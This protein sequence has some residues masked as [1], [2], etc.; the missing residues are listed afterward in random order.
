LAGAVV[1]TLPAYPGVAGVVVGCFN[2][3]GK[4]AGGLLLLRSDVNWKQPENDNNQQRD[5]NAWR[6]NE[7]WEE[8][9]DH[10]SHLVPLLRSA[11]R[12]PC[13]AGV[14]SNPAVYI[15]M[16]NTASSIPI[17]FYSSE[18]KPKNLISLL[19]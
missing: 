6:T 9:F 14:I 3:F 16:I 12:S 7:S 8:F 5:K 19:I 17:S 1:A 13:V 10:C 2:V 15:A 4:Y 11:A 18:F